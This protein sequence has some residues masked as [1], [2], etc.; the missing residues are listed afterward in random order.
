MGSHFVLS[1]NNCIGASRLT[2][3]TSPVSLFNA[4]GS[5]C[6]GPVTIS[7]DCTDI[8]YS[9][10]W[11]SGNTDIGSHAFRT[12]FTYPRPIITQIEGVTAEV[13]SATYDGGSLIDLFSNIYVTEVSI[14]HGQT[15][16]CEDGSNT[17]S[18]LITI[19]VIG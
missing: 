14:L 3:T 13:V 15:I 19:N 6:D 9:F 11:R 17:H 16:H 1:P 7:C 4:Y 5:F 12:S 8:S 18:N 10:F 2:L